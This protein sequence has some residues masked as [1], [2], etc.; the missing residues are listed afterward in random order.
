MSVLPEAT[1]EE[2]DL[3]EALGLDTLEGA[4]VLVR[5]EELSKDRLGTRR[6]TRLRLGDGSGSPVQWYLKRYGPDAGPRRLARRLTGR[7]RAGPVQRELEAIRRLQHA[8]VPTARPLAAGQESD[9]LGARRSYIVLAAVEG[10]ALERCLADC[11]DRWDEPQVQHFNAALAELVR[12][13][14]AAGWVHRD[15]YASHVFLDD[16]PDG[17]RLRLID[18]ARCF[19]PRWRRF[20]WRVKDLGQLKYSMPPAWVEQYWGEFLTGYL[21]GGGQARWERAIAR[22]VAAMRR[23]HRRRQRKEGGS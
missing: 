20:R 16:T 21:A 22:K 18:L 15:L 10:D 17:P 14:H 9:L 12:G 2:A 3:L 5:G 19:A 4:F 23:R 7:G 8:G 6:R 13:L 11:L 1:A